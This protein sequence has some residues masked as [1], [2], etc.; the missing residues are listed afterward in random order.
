MKTT[1]IATNFFLAAA[2]CSSN[3]VLAH[4][5]GRPSSSQYSDEQAPSK[6]DRELN[7]E[8]HDAL[9]PGWFSKGYDNV[10][11]QV[12]D[13]VVDL[14]GKVDNLEEKQKVEKNIAKIEGV[15][16]VNNQ[17]TVAMDSKDAEG[18]E[19]S[20]RHIDEE[21]NKTLKSSWFSK[22]YDK[23]NYKV[24]R[25]AVELTGAVDNIDDKVKIEKKLASID[26]VKKVNNQ[27]TVTE[28]EKGSSSKV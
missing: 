4:Q 5:D 27:I 13:G 6:S 21:I 11:F 26:G 24:H 1:V 7:E 9:K 12:S 22:G 2:L 20:D 17:L 14:Q 8:I 28:K 16:S 15:R 25:G 23:V 3:I 18:K 19:V 10:N